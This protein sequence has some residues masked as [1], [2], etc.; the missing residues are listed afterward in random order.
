MPDS[1]NAF[2]FYLFTGKFNLQAYKL[3]DYQLM[4]DKSVDMSWKKVVNNGKFALSK[5][6]FTC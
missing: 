2:S 3:E 6:T 4:V 5:G 1:S